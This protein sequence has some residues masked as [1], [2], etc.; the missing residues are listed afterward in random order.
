MYCSM[1]IYASKIFY[2]LNRNKLTYHYVPNSGFNGEDNDS[3]RYNRKYQ[4]K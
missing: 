3:E 2:Q 4:D 1:N